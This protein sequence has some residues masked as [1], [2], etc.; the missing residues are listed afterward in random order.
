[1]PI[2]TDTPR[3]P[4]WWLKVL[5]RKLHDRN[6]G[7]GWSMAAVERQRDSRPGLVLLRDWYR[8]DPPLPVGAAGWQAGFREFTRISRTNFAELVVEPTRFRMRPLAW[9]TAAAG[10]ETGDAK[11][12]QVARAND[13]G[14]VFSD[15]AKDMLS[16]GDAYMIVGEPR[17][18]GIPLITAET[19]LQVITAHATAT[20]EVIAALKMLRDEWDDSEYAYV[21]LPGEVWVARRESRTASTGGAVVGEHWSWDEDLSGPLP[22]GFEDVV[23]VVRASNLDGHGDF[24][25]HLDIL[26][27]INNGILDRVVAA[28]IQAFR[29]RAVKG[30]PDVYP[31]GHEHAGQEV[32]YTGVFEAAPGSMWQVPDGVEFWESA[33][34]DLSGLRLSIKDDVEQLAAVTATP[35]HLITPDAAS[36]SAEGA[37]LMREEHILK[38]EDRRTRAAGAL[39]RVMA[40]AFRFMGDD[41]RADVSQIETLWEPAERFSLTEK[42]SAAAQVKGTLPTEAIYTDILQYPPD[43][44]PRL[45]AQ[46]AGDLLYQALDVAG[47]SAPAVAPV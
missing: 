31:P 7:A 9:R 29:Q 24:E 13:F 39:A 10:D 12:L 6:R 15:F 18:S 35:L 19:P 40:L 34:N 47:A 30:L 26:G 46:R 45:N 44:V 36:G 25:T 41:A 20:G 1:V 8:G 28:K 27:R 23:P 42:A 3:S 43:A 21:Y 32:D 22:A 5:A 14:V 4:G 38:V 37:S 2:D 11:A 16:L 17:P 33:V